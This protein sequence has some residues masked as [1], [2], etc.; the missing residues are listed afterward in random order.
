[1]DDL[2]FVS[3]QH[4]LH[5]VSFCVARW[6]TDAQ[7]VTRVPSG[8]V[9][10]AKETVLDVNGYVVVYLTLQVPPNELLTR[11]NL[12]RT[13]L[14][15]KIQAMANFRGKRH[16]GCTA[17]YITALRQVVTVIDS[18]YQNLFHKGTNYT[19]SLRTKRNILGT[20]LSW[21]TGMPSTE[22]IESLKEANILTADAVGQVI[23]DNKRTIGIVNQLGRQQEAVV[24]KVNQLRSVMA[25]LGVSL[26]EAHIISQIQELRSHAQFLGQALLEYRIM[27]NEMQAIRAACESNSHSEITVPSELL[28]QLVTLPDNLQWQLY[29][30]YMTTESI[31]ELD[32]V[33]YCKIRI[34]T[35]RPEQHILYHIITLPICQPGG[36]CV[37]IG[38]ELKIVQGTQTEELYL[39]EFCLGQSP[40]MCQAGVIHEDTAQPCIH[41][42]INQDPKQISKCP[43]T[44]TDKAPLSKPVSTQ[45]INRYVVQTPSTTY[46]YRCP[47]RT[48]SPV[49]I[50]A[51]V[52]IIEVEPHCQLDAGIW[53]LKGLPVIET[54]VPGLITPAQPVSVDLP[55]LQLNW[56][57]INLPGP[58]EFD[59][60]EE[61]SQ[62][63]LLNP[64]ID[65]QVNDIMAKV[66]KHDYLPVYITV[67][68][69][70]SLGLI[71][72]TWY[73]CTHPRVVKCRR[74]CCPSKS[75]LTE[76]SMTYHRPTPATRSPKNP[77]PSRS[78]SL[79]SVVQVKLDPQASTNSV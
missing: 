10:A 15:Q 39:P 16:P 73:I 34:P 58:L 50:T 8:V 57:A 72:G 3:S 30:Q 47:N 42:M 52:Y 22:D 7:N 35:A 24:N 29:Y 25:S 64:Q 71:I 36:G 21:L 66:G 14:G 74:Q 43:V 17:P 46:R 11:W 65:N 53:L 48:P 33:I 20:A 19:L 79:R 49:P 75:K 45:V 60:Y 32:G 41:G 54:F 4:S 44:L 13:M 2:P 26:D 1:M 38:K 77:T 28:N 37:T 18:S 31:L 67:A 63:I 78:P 12:A 62:S 59:S 61:L 6:P 5:F 40:K 27:R 70:A 55:P 51:G 23:R 69:V 9:I 68:I 56:S 76:P